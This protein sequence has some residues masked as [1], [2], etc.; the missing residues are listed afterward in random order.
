M[1]YLVGH[2]GSPMRPKTSARNS[3][4][5][6]RVK[7]PYLGVELFHYTLVGEITKK[8]ASEDAAFFMP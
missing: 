3:G 2:A 6:Y 4:G 1:L 7:R 8:A 5:I